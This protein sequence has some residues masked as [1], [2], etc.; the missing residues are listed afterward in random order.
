MQGGDVYASNGVPIPRDVAQGFLYACRSEYLQ[1][2]DGGVGGF[3]NQAQISQDVG[4]ALGGEEQRFQSG[5]P[6]G[7]YQELCQRWGMQ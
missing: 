5:N 2:Q 4:E 3:F 6:Q 1:G 7:A